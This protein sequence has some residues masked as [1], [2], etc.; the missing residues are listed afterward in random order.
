MG[1]LIGSICCVSSHGSSCKVEV[2]HHFGFALFL[3]VERGL[4]GVGMIILMSS[5][6]SQKSSQVGCPSPITVS[7]ETV[8]KIF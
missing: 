5:I 2:Y 1:S 7:G 3:L 8:H 4:G 6:V